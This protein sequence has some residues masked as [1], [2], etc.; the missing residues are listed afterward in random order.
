MRI[1][2]AAK[3]FAISLAIWGGNMYKLFIIAKNNIKKHKGDVAIL[4][5]LMFLAAFMLFSSLSLMLS[6]KNLIEE[7]DRKYHVSDLIV[8][9]SGTDPDGLKEIISSVDNTGEYEAVP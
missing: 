3:N 4:F 9:A 6:G 1:R 2:N 8:F 7:C 5:A